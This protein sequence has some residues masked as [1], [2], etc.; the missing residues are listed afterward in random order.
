MSYLADTVMLLRFFEADG[1]IRKSLA[2]LKT[3][4]SDHERTIRELKINR[5]GLVIGAPMKGFR[6]VLSG[7]PSFVVKGERLIDGEAHANE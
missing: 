7:S 3:R 5:T 6:G 2:V 1:E 4:T